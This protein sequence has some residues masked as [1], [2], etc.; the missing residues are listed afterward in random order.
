MIYR[1]SGRSPLVAFFLTTA[2]ATGYVILLNR[3]VLK[4]DLSSVW[5]QFLSIGVPLILSSIVYFAIVRDDSAPKLALG[6]QALASAF[7]A[8]T[9]AWMLYVFVGFVF[10]DWQM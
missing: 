2:V 1:L 5:G 8:P 9:I 4:T 10:L 6:F 3:W 7:L